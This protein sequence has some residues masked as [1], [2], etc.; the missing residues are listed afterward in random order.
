MNWFRNIFHGTFQYLSGVF[1]DVRFFL[2]RTGGAITTAIVALA[3]VKE[4]RIATGDTAVRN[5]LKASN[6]INPVFWIV[7]GF[8]WL[9]RYFAS[10]PPIAGLQGLPALG[11]VLALVFCGT[12]LTPSLADRVTHARGRMM[13]H[14]GNSEFEKA[15][16]FS[17]QLC[18][19]E[20]SDPSLLFDRAELL[21]KMDR[22]NDALQTMAQLANERKYLPAM[23]WLCEK[24]L[25]YLKNSAV[26]DEQREV[27]LMQGLL[28]ILA[29]DP[30]NLKANAML[31]SIYAAQGQFSRAV[32]LLTK[33][34]QLAPIPNPATR[35][36]LAVAQKEVGQL[37]NSKANAVI[38]AEGLS[39]RNSREPYSV[40]RSIELL[41]AMIL[42]EQEKEA[43]LL[44][45]Q[46]LPK[47]TEQEQAELKWLLGEVYAQWCKR[48]RLKKYRTADD[49]A[50]ALDAIYR[51]VIAAPSNPYVTE[52]MV[53]LSCVTDVNDRV[54]QEQLEVALNAGV[55]PGLV[56]FILGTR[57]LLNL[58]GNAQEALQHFELAMQ[59]NESLPGLLNNIADAMVETDS[60][61][62][63]RALKLVD[64]AITLL[65]N[66]PY[67]F[68]TRGKI[69]LKKDEPR[70]AI[71]DLEKAL[72]AP[73]LR[74]QVHAEMAAAYL[75]MKDQK[76]YEYH[77]KM[78]ENYRKQQAAPLKTEEPATPAATP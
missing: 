47:R 8:G 48:L 26:P 15:D 52:E 33:A 17:R 44:I 21:D 59:H 36:M 14:A 22:K 70:K 58:N 77:T 30:Q 3:N 7:Q 75:A 50:Q 6:Y 4:G 11:C 56:H 63:E 29:I 41:R 16:F 1:F 38:S 35:Y 76:N 78:S 27:I 32:P 54:L 51:G 43:V 42:A 10:R 68:D 72:V 62:T 60:T 19:M 23:Q 2:N 57:L 34:V 67:F 73:E 20:P 25:E 5:P 65:P 9:F 12:L 55:S 69:L 53:Q 61:D 28:N 31:G 46:S 45:R 64:Q 18:F 71:A 40:Q 74:I 66:Q 49:L 37:E 13:L 39:E 24:D